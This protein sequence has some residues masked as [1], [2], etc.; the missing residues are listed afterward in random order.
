MLNKSYKLSD[1][2]KEEIQNLKGFDV[3]LIENAEHYKVLE[4]EKSNNIVAIFDIINVLGIYNKIL[5]VDIFPKNAKKFN[6]PKD[7]LKLIELYYF[8]FHSILG[9]TKKEKLEKFKIYSQENTVF[10]IF[11]GF[12]KK[13]QEEFKDMYQTKIYGNWIEILIKKK[14]KI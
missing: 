7:I 1:L 9:I 10:L 12:A 4:G 11:M 8:I 2:K 6:S 5:R 3:N 14:E 13:V